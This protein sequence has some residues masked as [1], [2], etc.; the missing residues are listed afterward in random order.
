MPILLQLVLASAFPALMIAA[1]I[2]D[3]TTY[4]IPNR[5]NIA[6]ALAFFPL[7]L[8]TTMPPPL[9]GLHLLVGTAALL[10][11][12]A[13]FALGWIGGG[14]AKLLAVCG[15]WL[16][17]PAAEAFLL[18]TAIAGG[19]FAL[20]LLSLRAPI[21]RSHMPATGWLARLTS[22][23]EPAPYGVA[24]AIGALAAFPA[25]ELIRIAHTSY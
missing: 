7:A 22:P 11:G 19:V 8:A 14:D 24:M 13:M 23:G 1:A 4:T 9:L 16:G 21:L 3:L 10:A 12:M 2:T 20:M 5:I 15:L 17:W 18:Y 25:A 6:L